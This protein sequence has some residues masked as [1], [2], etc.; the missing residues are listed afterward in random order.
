MGW[1][2]LL[3]RC[4]PGTALTHEEP[5]AALD[6]VIGLLPR[7]WI[8]AGEPFRPLAEEVADLTVEMREH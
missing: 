7:L 4:V 6:V 2:M 1:A 3:E 5:E 8:P